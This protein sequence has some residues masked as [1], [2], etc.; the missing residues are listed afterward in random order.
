MPDLTTKWD[1]LGVQLGCDV[2]PVSSAKFSGDD[3]SLELA[4]PVQLGSD[5]EVSSMF[6]TSSEDGFLMDL[7][8]EV[9]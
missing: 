6:K 4:A 9:L 7:R 5:S 3:S 8:G 2:A 1:Y